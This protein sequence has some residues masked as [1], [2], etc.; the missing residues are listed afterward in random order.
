MKRL[1]KNVHPKKEFFRL[2]NTFLTMKNLVW[3]IITSEKILYVVRQWAKVQIFNCE[4]FLESHCKIREDGYD[5]FSRASKT[6][7]YFNQDPF[8]YIDFLFPRGWANP[9]LG[10]V[11]ALRICDV[12]QV[13]LAWFSSDF[14]YSL[15]IS[16]ANPSK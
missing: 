16:K 13:I 1:K 7:F 15:D 6:S 9:K 2:P 10:G 11:D 8:N 4:Y 12:F 14:Y 5:I 3:E